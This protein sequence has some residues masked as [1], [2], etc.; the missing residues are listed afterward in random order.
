MKFEKAAR[1]A[2]QILAKMS[3]EEK[4][5]LI[6]GVNTMFTKGVPRLG[7]KGLRMADASMGLRDDATPATAFPAFI[8]LA[9]SWDKSL[10]REYG[11]A[12]GS[13][14]RAAGIDVLLGPGVN[15]Y[16]VP[17]CGRN[18]EY[19]G[20]DPVLTSAMAVSYIQ[21]AQEQGVSATVKHF[22]ANNSDWHRSVSDS[23]IDERT[24]RELY[25]FAFEKAVKESGVLALMTSYNLLNGEYTAEKRSLV[26]DLLQDEWGFEGVVMSDWGG[27]WDS[28]KAFNSGLMLEMG[29]AKVWTKEK[30]QALS[31]KG[32]LDLKELDRKV[33][34]ILR[35]T[36]AIDELQE[37]APKPEGR[38]KKHALTAL[39]TARRGVTLLKNSSNALPLKAK[40]KVCV[41]GPC[42][43][44]TPTS[45][46]GAAMVKAIDPAS[47]LGALME[48][49]PEIQFSTSVKEAASADFAIVC[50]GLDS[51]VEHEG[52]D[53]QFELPWEQV[54]LIHKCLAANPNTIVVVVAGGGI[55][56]D[57]WADKAKAIVHA[58]YPGENGAQAVAEILLG[59][60]NPSGKL[61]MSIERKWSDSAAFSNY[62]PDAGA[63]Y[64][65]PDYCSQCRPF[66]KVHYEEGVFTGY[67]HFD[68]SGIEPLF[69]FGHG[70]SFTKFEYSALK[71]EEL[72]GQALR[73][74]FKVKNAGKKAGDEIAQLYVGDLKASVPRPAREL[75]GFERVPLKPGESK[76]VSIE[77]DKRAFSFYDVK[78]KGWKLEPGEFSIEIG[79]SSKDI[80]LKGVAKIK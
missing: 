47:I 64:E 35:W 66:F 42:A 75:K 40:A 44:P 73:V 65:N 21:G 19:L 62:I 30:L 36:F 52:S 3:F 67:R 71:I 31:K 76:T 22:A 77:L 34:G 25:L 6:C 80:R 28:E 5:D 69:P 45:G 72:K 12:V 26:R 11:A 58:W 50:V 48:L 18:F 23:A 16:R 39:E 68:K 57:A 17:H 24:L 4:A 55:S 27:T 2:K 20:E 10:A 70:L 13:E 46:G 1:K 33:L 41:A 54:E 59:I 9:A 15:L 49:A 60:V 43:C 7:V 14:F 8:A 38:C 29:G 63:Y 32:K 74:S 56:M 53:R 78:G 51:K 61:P 79:A 37:K